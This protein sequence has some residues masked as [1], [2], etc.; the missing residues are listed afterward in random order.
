[1]QSM[2]V[3][4]VHTVEVLICMG[5]KFQQQKYEIELCDLRTHVTHMGT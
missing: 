4:H 5:I 1:M 3:E 2:E